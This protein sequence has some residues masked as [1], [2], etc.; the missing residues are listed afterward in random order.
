MA[1]HPES[2]LAKHVCVRP[3]YPLKDPD[4]FVLAMVCEEC[5]G[6]QRYLYRRELY[7]E[8]PDL[9]NGPADF[10]IDPDVH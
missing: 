7:V 4:G 3:Q 10:R 5:E 6:A 8:D 2:W 9:D 1:M